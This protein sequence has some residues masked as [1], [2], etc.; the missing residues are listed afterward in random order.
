[1][2]RVLAI[3]QRERQAQALFRVADT[4]ESVLTPAIRAAARV[5]VREIIPGVS[6]RRVVLAH[7]SPLPLAE[8]RAPESPGRLA[9]LLQPAIFG[10]HT[11]RSAARPDPPHGHCTATTNARTT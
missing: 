3:P 2:D 1:E 7:G 6:S 10:G 4:G 9:L 8:I 11:L 5:I